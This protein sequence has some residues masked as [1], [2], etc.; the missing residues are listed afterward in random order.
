MGGTWTLNAE[1]VKPGNIAQA[2]TPAKSRQGVIG[3][4][5][6]GD[7]EVAVAEVLTCVEWPSARQLTPAA[8]Y[9]SCA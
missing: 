5:Y 1:A 6:G 8:G 7:D 3:P 4:D 9:R 2:S